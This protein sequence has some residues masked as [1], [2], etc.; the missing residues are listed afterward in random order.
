MI[1]HVEIKDFVAFHFFN[2]SWRLHSLGDI[3][4]DQRWLCVHISG[5]MLTNFVFE[6]LGYYFIGDH[7]LY[8][9]NA[10]SETLSLDKALC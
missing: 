5:D 6:F 10:N 4:L 3:Y 1:F 8:H 7:L 9:V 2:S